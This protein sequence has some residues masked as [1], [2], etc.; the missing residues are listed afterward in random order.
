M[1]VCCLAGNIQ[2]LL[3]HGDNAHFVN[4]TITKDPDSPS[5]GI[6]TLNVSSVLPANAFGPT[7]INAVYNGSRECSWEPS[8]NLNQHPV[9]YAGKQDSLT[10]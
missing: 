6:A 5:I 9:I 4:A 1:F 7:R 3:V 2:W 10:M 8:N